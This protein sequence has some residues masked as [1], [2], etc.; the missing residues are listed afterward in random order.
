MKLD[1][2]NK[3]AIVTGASEGLGK[4]I[5]LSLA[6]EGVRVAISGRRQAVLRQTAKEIEAATGSSI[7]TF[8]GDMTHADTVKHFVEKV[9]AETKTIHILI[10]NVGQAT[11]GMFMSLD[12]SQWQQAFEINLMS[13]IYTSINVVPYMQNQKWGR[14]INISALSGKEPSDELM[15]SNVVKSGLVSFSKTLSRELASDNI[16]VNCISPGLI[17]SPQNDHYFSKDDR[18]RALDRIPLGRFGYPEEF[19]DTV[20]FLCSERASYVTGIN[21]LVDGGASRGL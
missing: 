3:V 21:L 10:N 9:I 6:N 20:T 11:R 19:A 2:D 1:L 16:L 18:E 15:A 12:Q 17:E 8:T 13:A 5:A 7:L 4:A 14:I